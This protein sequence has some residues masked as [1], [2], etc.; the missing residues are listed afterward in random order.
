G[1][2]ALVS[3]AA[4]LLVAMLPAWRTARGTVQAA[5]RASGLATTSDRAAMR[6]RA[7]LLALQVGLSVTLLVVTGLLS[8][9]FF[10]LVN[11]DRGFAAD[12]VLAVGVSMPAT[13]YAEERVRRAAYDRLLAAIRA[14]P[15]V[16]SVT[17][18]SI[19][20]LAGQGQVNFVRA[21]G[22]TRPRSLLA[23]ANFRFIAPEYFR[24][25]G[26]PVV[27]GRA[28]TDA[29]RDRNRDAPALVSSRTASLMWP[30][31]DAL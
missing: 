18:S 22:D 15:G 24:T 1:F 2:A 25:L 5:L 27:R 12:R 21:A 8:L 7:A 31:Q 3:I 20:P 23:T 13:R 14:V 29:E 9:S 19:L 30:G 26:I 10:R 28:F 6:T 11:V 17:T 4:G 16:V